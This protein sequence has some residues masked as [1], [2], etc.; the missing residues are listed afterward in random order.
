MQQEEM[1]YFVAGL[2]V[3]VESAKN[4]FVIHT[5]DG[6]IIA[7]DPKE[8]LGVLL[9]ELTNHAAVAAAFEAQQQ[10]QRDVEDA[11]LVGDAT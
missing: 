1:Q 11:E 9:G 2:S 3:T 5:E 7:K 4:G 8:L 10:A 6:V